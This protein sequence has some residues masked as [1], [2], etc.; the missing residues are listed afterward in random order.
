MP[1]MD[2]PW[3]GKKLLIGVAALSAAFVLLT[4]V[5]STTERPTLADRTIPVP[6]LSNAGSSLKGSLTFFGKRNGIDVYEV[7]FNN[8]EPFEHLAPDRIYL[9][10][11]PNSSSVSNVPFDLALTLSGTG[12]HLVDY[13]GYRYTD[14]AATMERRDIN[15]LRFK[16]RF[17]GQ[18]FASKT[19][20]NND[21]LHGNAIAAFES[22][23][24]I[25]FL[26]SDGSPNGVRLDPAGSLYVIVVNSPGGADLAIRN[27]TGCGNGILEGAE[28]CDDGN[29]EDEDTCRNACTIG[30]PIPFDNGPNGTGANLAVLQFSG[31]NGS[32]ATGAVA[33]PLVRFMIAASDA[34]K[35]SSL[36]FAAETGSLTSLERYAL[37][38]DS[39]KDGLTDVKISKDV[40][41]VGNHVSFDVPDTWSGA[42]ALSL[43]GTILELKADVPVH[44]QGTK[45]LRVGFDRNVSDFIVA[46]RSAGTFPLFGIRQNGTCTTQVCQIYFTSAVSPLWTLGRD[47]AVCGNQV[48]NQG[49]QCDNGAQNGVVCDSVNGGSCTYCSLQCENVT[50]H[51]AASSVASSEDSSSSPSLCG[52][53]VIDQGEECDDASSDCDNTC[54][55]TIPT[56]NL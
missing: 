48:I 45:H 38:M 6:F 41:P 56:P 52:N 51:G 26:P 44:L 49:E 54:H 2:A 20:R 39:D 10:H 16:D 36:S 5:R 24:Q 11:V 21:A 55:L 29:T 18:F 37:W 30:F 31:T 43:T 8:G 25:T 46:K 13:Y 34:T 35:I 7:K 9:V 27:L 1:T 40:T 12:G 3:L 32:A 42:V 50:V 17:P 33:I 15:A 14:A 23:N 4:I 47:P 19:A 53:G 28:Q 22:A